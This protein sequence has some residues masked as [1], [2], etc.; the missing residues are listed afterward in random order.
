MPIPENIVP[1]NFLPPFEGLPEDFKY[2]CQVGGWINWPWSV[3]V[4]V[5]G[6]SYQGGWYAG[7]M[8]V[9]IPEGKHVAEITP[10]NNPPVWKQNAFSRLLPR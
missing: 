3:D 5:D 9:G 7:R 4:K 1:P 8:T 10:Y 6:I 2:Q